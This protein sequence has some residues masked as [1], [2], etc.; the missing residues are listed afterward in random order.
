[1][2]FKIYVDETRAFRHTFVVEVDSEKQ[3]NEILDSVE[4]ES[5]LGINE[6]EDLLMERCNVIE[7]IKDQD[8]DLG[9]IECNDYDNES[10]VDQ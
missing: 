8:G 2:K 10:E 6:Y 1:M 5:M 9:E 7:S 4:S 3:L